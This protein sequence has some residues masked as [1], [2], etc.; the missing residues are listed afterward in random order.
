MP[1][2]KAAAAPK[3]KAFGGMYILVDEALSAV[4]GLKVGA[5]M[6]SPQMAK[7][8]WAYIKSNDLKKKD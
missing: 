4:M 3:K 8:L 6:T 5:K 2:E 1:K 7:N